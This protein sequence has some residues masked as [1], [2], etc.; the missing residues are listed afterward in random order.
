MKARVTTYNA[1]GDVY[2]FI[3]EPYHEANEVVEVEYGIW[4]EEGVGK[5]FHAEPIGFHV[6][7][8]ARSI[9]D[10]PIVKIKIEPYNPFWDINP[11]KEV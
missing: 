10:Y 2:S 7:D 4:Y 8:H 5:H 3:Y 1:N 11:A 9:F 6:Y